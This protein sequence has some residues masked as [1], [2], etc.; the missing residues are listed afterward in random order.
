M[1]THRL[2]AAALLAGMGTLSAAPALADEGPTTTPPVTAS[3]PTT[4]RPSTRPSASGHT[5]VPAP[6]SAPTPSSTASA[7][8]ATAAS[9]PSASIGAFDCAALTA[10]VT[11]DN[12]RSST[13]TTFVLTT[14]VT[15]GPTLRKEEVIPTGSTAEVGVDL[16]NNAYN[17]VVVTVAGETAAASAR[18]VFCGEKPRVTIG[19]FDCAARQAPVTL[20]NRTG[21]TPFLFD[22][23]WT[24]SNTDYEQSESYTV[25]AGAVRVVTVP[26]VDHAWTSIWVR[27][28]F[29]FAPAPLDQLVV[30]QRGLC[31]EEPD[32]ARVVVSSADCGTRTVGVTIDNR[33][34]PPRRPR[35]TT[36]WVVTT[37]AGKTSFTRYLDEAR[38]VYR[39][40]VPVELRPG[41][42]LTV[43]GVVP[44][45]TPPREVL[46]SEPLVLR[47]AT[48]TRPATNQ[49]AANQPPTPQTSPAAPAVTT[50]Q[51]TSEQQLSATGT[52]ELP[53]LVL[54]AALIT[55]GLALIRLSTQRRE[56]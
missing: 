51:Q 46:Y 33:Q 52:T 30:T 54:A 10:P 35:S 41:G 32:A 55:S 6:T 27:E 13:A 28:G 47:C 48:P 42:H 44:G 20:D 2:L 38:E 9:D 40:T 17:E 3:S 37:Y 21:A 8:P 56:H 22:V 26:L 11:L 12:M 49:P 24:S 1:R 25:A 15:A 50:G 7:R 16:V 4:V 5:D 19:T 53:A 29:F 34:T 39:L 45:A 18:P 36:F 31:G 14:M 43:T 23:Q